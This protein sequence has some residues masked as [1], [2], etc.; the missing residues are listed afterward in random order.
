[1]TARKAVAK[2]LTPEFMESFSVPAPSGWP[3][4]EP[5]MFH[6]VL[7]EIIRAV[8]DITEA[9]PAAVLASL[10]AFSS[11]YIGDGPYLSLSGNNFNAAL[12][13]VLVGPTSNGRKGTAASIARLIRRLAIPELPEG[14]VGSGFGSGEGLVATLA[15]RDDQR[16]LLEEEEFAAVLTVAGREGSILSE[17]TRKTWDGSP[18]QNNVK[19]G[20][21]AASDYHLSILGHITPNELERKLNPGEIANGFGNRFLWF[22]SHRRKGLVWDDPRGSDVF[23]SDR[24]SEL[25]KV[26]GERLTKATSV[27]RVQCTDSARILWRD[28]YKEGS[29]SGSGVCA[30]LSARWE[31][32]LM[33]LALVFALIDGESSVDAQHITAAHAVWRYSEATVRYVYGESSGDEVVDKLEAAVSAAGVDGLTYSEIQRLWSGHLSTK[34]RNAAVEKL[35]ASGKARLEVETTGGK[36]KRTLFATSSNGGTVTI[37]QSP[38]AA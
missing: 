11:A 10:L 35:M 20:R 21:L 12:F 7:G 32:Q 1:M 26:L 15:D 36:T 5:E 24:V 29:I 16:L 17:I 25:A 18:L 8:E 38:R 2:P 6:G 30:E 19:G 9:D 28:L 14:F 34:I 4:A 33:R 13:A 22:A 3:S 23:L 27:G 31:A 37:G